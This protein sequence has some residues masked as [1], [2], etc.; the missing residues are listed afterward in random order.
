MIGCNTLAKTVNVGSLV[1]LKTTSKC[2]CVCVCV[3]G[4]KKEPEMETWQERRKRVTEVPICGDVEKN[5]RKSV[6]VKNIF[7]HVEWQ[8]SI[9]SQPCHTAVC[10]CACSC[11]CVWGS[12]E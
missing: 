3:S 10:A 9:D 2:V 7:L 5:V 8:R 6:M 12:E 4:R 1:N 11:V